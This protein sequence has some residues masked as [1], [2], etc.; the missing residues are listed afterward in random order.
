MNPTEVSGTRPVGMP[1]LPIATQD[2]T[3]AR[4]VLMIFPIL[5]IILLRWLELS[6]PS[7]QRFISVFVVVVIGVA[8]L[9]AHIASSQWHCFPSATGGRRRSVTG[10]YF[11]ADT[12][13]G[14]DSERSLGNVLHVT[15]G[16]QSR[17]RAPLALPEHVLPQ[18]VNQ[19]QMLNI[20]TE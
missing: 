3:Q 17:Q 4:F 8:A 10:T 12:G 5:S 19:I 1:P 2:H 14:D 18:R 16:H 13:D 7:W 11:S 20:L 6:E 15:Q 9:G